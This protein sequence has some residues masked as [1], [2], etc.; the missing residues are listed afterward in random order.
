MVSCDSAPES[1]SDH[2][3]ETELPGKKIYDVSCIACHGKDGK[4]GAGGASDLSLST[5]SRDSV[6][7]ILK[8]GRN[9]ML[10]QTHAFKNEEQLNELIDY[11]E[12]IRY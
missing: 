6:G 10:P 1:T 3:A 9:N 11:L 7:V 8:K 2:T 5:L 4:L 12:S